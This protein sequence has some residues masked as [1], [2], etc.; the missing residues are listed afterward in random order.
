MCWVLAE[1]YGGGEVLASSG[2]M[3]R[4]GNVEFLLRYVDVESVG[5]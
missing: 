5:L 3:W 1:V 2:S 4:C